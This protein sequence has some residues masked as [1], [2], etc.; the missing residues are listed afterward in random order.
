MDISGTLHALRIHITSAVKVLDLPVAGA[1][2]YSYAAPA[3]RERT[4]EQI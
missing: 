4:I 1:S 3:G 2:L